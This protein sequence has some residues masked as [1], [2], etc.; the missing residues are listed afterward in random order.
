[1]PAFLFLT[2]PTPPAFF[3]ARLF[4]CSIL[5]PRVDFMLVP[6]AKGY[7]NIVLA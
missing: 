4:A 1:M 6:P 5:A 2:W 3:A 7:P